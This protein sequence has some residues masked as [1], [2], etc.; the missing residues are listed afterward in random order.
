MGLGKTMAYGLAPMTFGT[1]IL[2][3]EGGKKAFPNTGDAMV[4][5]GATGAASGSVG[6]PIGA[7]IGG[8]VGAG[9]GGYSK[10]KQNE[11]DKNQQISDAYDTAA[12]DDEMTKGAFERQR[13]QEEILKS[14]MM[15]G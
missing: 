15:E 2:A 4:E 1:S 12:Q 14:I 7:L 11:R 9:M 5:G 6:G 8:V 13:Q 10:Y 3:Y